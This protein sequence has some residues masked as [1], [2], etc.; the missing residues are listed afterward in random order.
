M[1]TGNTELVA[2]RH[3][4]SGRSLLAQSLTAHSAYRGIQTQVAGV[5]QAAEPYC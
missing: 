4:Y 1:K 5:K 3:G 2:L